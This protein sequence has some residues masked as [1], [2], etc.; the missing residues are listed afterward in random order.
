M[1]ERRYNEIIEMF[2]GYE[3][4][5]QFDQFFRNFEI[6]VANKVEGRRDDQ[7][8]IKEIIKLASYFEAEIEDLQKLSLD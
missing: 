4:I 2:G 7:K 5:E 8:Y 1:A 3:S 6:V